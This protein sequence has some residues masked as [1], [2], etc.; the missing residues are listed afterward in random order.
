MAPL[1]T[2]D[3]QARNPLKRLFR[4]PWAVAALSFMALV[5]LVAA[6]GPLLAPHSPIESNLAD[7]LK[8][9]GT[10]GHLL[11]TDEL[12]RDV[13]SR[14]LYGTR[15]SVGVGFA[16][17]AVAVAL[18]VPL[19]LAAGYFGSWID[20]LVSRT[21]D[22]FLAFP[23][24]LLAI[25]VIAALGPGFYHAMLAVAIAGIPYYIRIARGSALAL[26]HRD[27]VEAAKAAG[28]SH[29]RILWSHLLPNALSPLLVAATLDVGWMI[30]A[31]AGLSFLGLG[32][33]PP[34]AEWGVMLS[35][36]RQ[37][38]RVAPHLTLVPG[39]AIFLVVLALNI[40]GDALRDALDPRMGGKA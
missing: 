8:P 23:Y 3:L 36:G 39:T 24:V 13:L 4:D 25:A 5:F 15:P 20:S 18:G 19:G 2:D 26:R 34:M 10:P 29:L 33:Q 14:L 7:R 21:T 22:V 38:V 1:D 28:A 11:G 12:G 37:F 40:L 35:D 16:A 17:V 31:A 6:V 32:A 9:V 27:F 30:T